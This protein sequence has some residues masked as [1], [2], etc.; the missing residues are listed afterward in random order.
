MMSER[1]YAFLIAAIVVAISCSSAYAEQ[2]PGPKDG[3]STALTASQPVAAEEQP[4]AVK[5]SNEEPAP[6]GSSKTSSDILGKVRSG[7]VHPFI[8]ITESFNDNIFYTPDNKISDFDTLLSPGI[9]IAVPRLKE[10]EVP[11]IE[12]A[13][14]T[15]GGL[16]MSSFPTKYPGSYQTYL[17]YRADIERYLRN[18]SENTTSHTLEG[19]F[20]YNFRG[21]LSVDVDDQFLKS[22][23]PRA[24]SEFSEL[25]KF[26][27]NYF[28]T[29]L[30]YELG[31]RTLL[32]LDY[33]HYGI[34][35]TS[36]D[37]DFRDRA[38]NAVAAYIFYKLRSRLAVFIEYDYIRVRYEQDVLSDSTE[39]HVF[40][41]VRWD[42]T[43]R[44]KGMVKVG[45]GIKDFENPA[46]ANHGDL[47]LEAQFDHQFTPKRSV[48]LT[49]SRKTNETDIA[50]TDFI[51]S[52]KLRAAYT[53]RLATK[54]TGTVDLSYTDDEYQ[55]VITIGS[56]TNKLR[57]KYYNA[58]A[59]LRYDFRDWLKF[60]A[61]LTYSKR[62]SNFSDFDYVNKTIFIRLTATL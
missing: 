8:S 20:Q 57:N 2:A 17:L 42:I 51:I 24:T 23:N 36:V 31:D 27:S 58:G 21:G 56:E 13:T 22:H 29:V 33:G 45:Y 47:I 28:S 49:A 59:A 41:G 54:I 16:A 19:A 46:L 61:G 15:P 38:D 26:Q 12:T 48:Q 37:N 60:D 3:D 9:W 10:R 52:D 50:G 7:Y 55:D 11:A 30:R 32:R 1:F 40:A 35:Y 5:L 39:H 6:S 34:Q 4:A 53:Q 43:A 18:S 44:S 62:V 14:M 25:D